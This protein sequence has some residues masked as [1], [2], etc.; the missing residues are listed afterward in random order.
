MLDGEVLQARPFASTFARLASHGDGSCLWHSLAAS[1]N[2]RGYRDL[3]H[4]PSVR[5]GRELRRRVVTRE[6]WADYAARVGLADFGDETGL[7]AFEEACDVR[8]PAD[9]LTF[10]LAAHVLRLR[11]VVLVSPD[12][13]Y[14]T[15]ELVEADA[16]V[17]LI[18]W[19][20]REHF[21]PIVSLRPRHAPAAAH[22]VERALRALRREGEASDAEEADAAIE[23]SAR[24]YVG[25]LHPRDPI[26]G[27]LFDLRRQGG[28]GVVARSQEP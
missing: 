14:D 27:A 9:N 21:E 19:L 12:E 1:L 24:G 8:R 17:A 7:D 25:L 13:M 2:W 4:T 16:P 15:A 23:P 22:A 3:A 6:H 28:S 20:H 18:A 11:I 5:A 10:A 26:V